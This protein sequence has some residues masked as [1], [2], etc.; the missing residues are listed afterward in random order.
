MRYDD[1]SM[2]HHINQLGFTLMELMI[3]MMIIGILVTIVAGSFMQTKLKSRDAQR[4]SDI[5]QLQRSLEAYFNDYQQYPDPAD[6]GTGKIQGCGVD[7]SNPTVC[8]WGG[9]FSAGTGPTIYMIQLPNDPKQPTI[10]YFYRTDSTHMKYQLFTVLEN[11]Q[12][13]DIMT[14]SAPP[15]CGDSVTSVCNYG[16]SS[17]NA[18][19]TDTL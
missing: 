11:A 8:D 19:P 12:D 2:K 13:L 15:T 10:Q 5:A 17:S 6:D 9:A 7:Q 1:S 3:V 4:K 16:R 14:F 18:K